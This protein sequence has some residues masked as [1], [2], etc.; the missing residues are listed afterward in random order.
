[1][2]FSLVPKLV[3]LNDP[4][5]PLLCITMLNVLAFEANYVKLVEGRA[6]LS[7]FGNI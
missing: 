7:A 2:E 3:T 4:G 6:T 1:M 5:Q